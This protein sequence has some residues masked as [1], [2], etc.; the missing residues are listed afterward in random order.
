[1]LGLCVVA[2]ALDSRARHVLTFRTRNKKLA[3]AVSFPFSFPF[4]T[5]SNVSIH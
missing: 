2:L 4:A 5:L 3:A 1:M